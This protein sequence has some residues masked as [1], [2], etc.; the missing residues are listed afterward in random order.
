MI[1]FF[2]MRYER[3]LNDIYYC[4]WVVE[5]TGVGAAGAGGVSVVGAGVVEA[6]VSGGVVELLLFPV[7]VFTTLVIVSF[8]ALVIV[9]IIVEVES[10]DE[11][12]VVVELFVVDVSVA[13]DVPIIASTTFPTI[14][15]SVSITVDEDVS[16]VEVEDVDVSVLDA[17]VGVEVVAASV[18]VATTSV[19]V[20][21]S[22]VVEVEREIIFSIEIFPESSTPWVIIRSPIFISWKEMS[23]SF[24]VFIVGKTSGSIS[25]V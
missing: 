11:A 6:E 3:F 15:L 13:V 12:D 7:T 14:F 4:V 22:L 17:L 1:I 23:V 25:K 8:T 18:V 5:S 9:S 10:V 2:T 24:F 19:E 20:A 21:I 16:S